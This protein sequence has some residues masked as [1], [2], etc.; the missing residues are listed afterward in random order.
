MECFCLV[1]QQTSHTLLLLVIV[2]HE[3]QIHPEGKYEGLDGIDTTQTHIAW[4]ANNWSFFCSDTS[5][6]YHG[7]CLPSV[8][9]LCKPIFPRHTLPNLDHIFAISEVIFL[10]SN[11]H[12]IQ[13]TISTNYK[14]NAKINHHLTPFVDWCYCDREVLFEKVCLFVCSFAKHIR[15]R[16]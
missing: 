2:S 1:C 5:E 7:K 14:I 3:V 12:L 13:K 8:S 11:Q 9:Y 15:G 16:E 4:M 6:N 10:N